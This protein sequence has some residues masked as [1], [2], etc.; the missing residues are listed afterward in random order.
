MRF[1]MRKLGVDLID[2]AVSSLEEPIYQK[3]RD[4]SSHALQNVG[5]DLY[6]TE[7]LPGFENTRAEDVLFLPPKDEYE[8]TGDAYGQRQGVGALDTKRDGARTKKLLT[9]AL[10]LAEDDGV[11]LLGDQPR[12]RQGSAV[13]QRER[14]SSVNLAFT[15]VDAGTL[16]EMSDTPDPGIKSAEDTP[17]QQP[18]ERR[19]VIEQSFFDHEMYP[20]EDFDVIKESS[21]DFSYRTEPVVEEDNALSDTDGQGLDPNASTVDQAWR[22]FR[23]FDADV[24][25]S[26]IVENRIEA[27]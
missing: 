9:S 24:S 27:G 18:A 3:W 26:D 2:K 15:D 19:R 17:M 16:G 1:W 11:V 12:H 21:A 6:N 8:R 7:L 23:A 5:S 4:V 14:E 10:K 20:T 25:S 22:E 13:A